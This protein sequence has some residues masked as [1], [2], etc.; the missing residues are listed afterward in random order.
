MTLDPGGARTREEGSDVLPAISLIID[1]YV[2]QLSIESSILGPV[3][4]TNDGYVEKT[5][6]RDSILQNRDGAI[7][8]LELAD[9]ELHM[10]CVTVIGDVQA[11]CLWASDSLVVGQGQIENTQH[12]CFRFS[13]AI[14]G[15]GRL[16]K[17]FRP[18]WI[19]FPNRLFTSTRFG[20]PGYMQL[21]ENAPRSIVRGAENSAEMGAYNA[22]INPIKLDSLQTKV[23]EYMPFGLLPGYIFKT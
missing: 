16:P 15:G 22:L 2:D 17:P 5:V 7:P 12:G 18:V 14:N 3:K 6:I 19:E 23:E 10:Q 9:C 4:I 1:G 8:A 20:D 11:Q 13:A 21:S